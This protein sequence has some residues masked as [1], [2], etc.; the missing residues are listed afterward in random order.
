MRR[1]PSPLAPGVAD[2]KLSGNGSEVVEGCGFGDGVSE[3]D[4][5]VSSSDTSAAIAIAPISHSDPCSVSES[6][7]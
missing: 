5:A 6:K 4:F 3:I 7:E 2:A 1:P